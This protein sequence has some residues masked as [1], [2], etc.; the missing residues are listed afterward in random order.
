MW[1]IKIEEWRKRQKRQYGKVICYNIL[2]YY[3]MTPTQWKFKPKEFWI[4]YRQ[5]GSTWKLLGFEKRHSTG[6]EQQVSRKYLKWQDEHDS[7]RSETNILNQH[8]EE[9]RSLHLASDNGIV[10]MVA[11]NQQL[12]EKLLGVEKDLDGKLQ[13]VN[14]NANSLVTKVN[15]L[16]NETK[17]NL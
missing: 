9:V 6:S 2:S 3:P 11:G 14:E 1:R 7:I 15:S 5:P 17:N 12:L 13:G 16:D 8:L 10:E 4:G